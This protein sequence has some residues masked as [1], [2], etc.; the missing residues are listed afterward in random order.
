MSTTLPLPRLMNETSST[1]LHELQASYFKDD[2][3]ANESIHRHW[4]ERSDI[5]NGYA[6]PS[7]NGSGS[8]SGNRNT[9]SNID[10]RG[11]AGSDAQ[12]LEGDHG[13]NGVDQQPDAKEKAVSKVSVRDRI[14]CITWT[15]FTY[16]NNGYWRNCKCPL[17]EYAISR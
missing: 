4:W 11:S 15:W 17:F 3:S 16:F 8:G 12:G 13:V 1:N 2:L 5:E 6:D 9:D 7:A 14:G 10:N